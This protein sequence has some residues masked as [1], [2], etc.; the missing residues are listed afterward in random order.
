MLIA[1]C[2]SLSVHAYRYSYH[3]RVALLSVVDSKHR[4]VHSECH[5]LTNNQEGL[6]ILLLHVF[7][8]QQP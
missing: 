2:L 6:V 1:P 4:R 7:S 5:S 3:L 8:L